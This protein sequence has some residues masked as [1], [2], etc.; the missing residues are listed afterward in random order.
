MPIEPQIERAKR[1]LLPKL[2]TGETRIWKLAEQCGVTRATI[3]LWMRCLMDAGF[4]VKETV[5]HVKEKVNGR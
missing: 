1:D 4:V 2:L 3:H 5:L